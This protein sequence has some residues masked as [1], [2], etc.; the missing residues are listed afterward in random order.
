MGIEPFLV[1]ASCNLVL[2]QRL[3]RKI[4]VECKVETEVDPQV[5][6]DIGFTE[7]QIARGPL[8]RGTGCRTCGDTGYKGRIALYEVMPMRDRTKEMVLQG[9]SAAEIKQQMI[10][11]GVLTLRM[12][13][14][15]KCMESITT[16]DEVLRCTVSDKS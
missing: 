10:Q 15:N 5:L 12:A 3:A 6:R 4:C 16:I 8:F 14:I 7:E 11:D 1:T 13:A 2:A 9:S